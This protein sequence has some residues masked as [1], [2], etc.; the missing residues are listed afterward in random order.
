MDC[1]GPH[2]LVH[3]VRPIP[4]QFMK[5][6]V[7]SNKNDIID[8]SELDKD[9]DFAN[10]SIL[11]AAEYGNLHRAAKSLRVKK[12]IIPRQADGDVITLQPQC[13]NPHLCCIRISS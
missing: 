2:A 11:A 4:R 9:S 10:S 13:L 8:A 3:K 12:Y 6:Y 5:P 1:Q 7:K